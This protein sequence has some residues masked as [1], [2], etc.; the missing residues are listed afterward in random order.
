MFKADIFDLPGSH[1]L[2]RCRPAEFNLGNLHDSA[3]KH[4]TT[5]HVL[6]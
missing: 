3:T 5:N 4:Y 6:Y 1:K 2:V